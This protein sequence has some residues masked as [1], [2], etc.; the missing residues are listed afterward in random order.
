MKYE[1]KYTAL[2]EADLK[3]LPRVYPII[4]KMHKK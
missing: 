4:D 2:S 1:A 3:D